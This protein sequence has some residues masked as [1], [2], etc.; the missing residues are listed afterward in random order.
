MDSGVSNAREDSDKVLGFM[1]SG[2]L[3][4]GKYWNEFIGLGILGY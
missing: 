4:V 2:F 1:D 3:G